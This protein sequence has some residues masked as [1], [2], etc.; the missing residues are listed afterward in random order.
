MRSGNANGLSAVS[1]EAS[2]VPN[3]CDFFWCSNMTVGQLVLD[4]GDG[5]GYR[6][7][8]PAGALSNRLFAWGDGA[9][10]VRW[11]YHEG[12]GSVSLGVSGGD[13]VV[14]GALAGALGRWRSLTHVIMSGYRNVL[15]ALGQSPSASTSSQFSLSHAI[16][17]V[18]PTI[19]VPI[20][21]TH[22]HDVLGS[23]D[24][25]ATLQ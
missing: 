19:P 18:L 14:D 11:L 10:W 8:A 23:V 12:S 3:E 5:R 17:M 24:I 22:D 4:S 2:A 9:I 13:A 1:N 16:S 21:L 20:H 7:D 6:A 15:H 25:S